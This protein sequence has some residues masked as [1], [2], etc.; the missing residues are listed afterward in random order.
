MEVMKYNFNVLIMK[1]IQLLILLTISHYCFGQMTFSDVTT[2]AGI[3]HQFKVYE[4]MFGGGACVFDVNKDG[5]EDLY[6]TGGMNSDAL[7]LNNGDGTF[8][9]IIRG[10]GLEITDDYVTQG[11]SG[12]DVNKD[13]WVDLFITTITTKDT[14]QTIP[15]AK[16]LFFLNNGDNTFKDATKK[17][18]LDQLNC[19][20]TAVSF[21][22]FNCDGF[23]DAYVGNYFLEYDGP[24]TEINDATIVN[25]SK[26]AQGYLLLNVGGKYFKNVYDDYGL[27]HKG[28]GFGGVWTDFDN[29]NDLDLLINHDFGYKAK[30]NYFLRNDY[31]EKK[32]SYIEKDID[33]DLRINAMTAAVGDYNNDE[34]LDYFIT[35]IKFNRF[36]TADALGGPYRDIA[37][38]MGT[39]IFT[40]SWGA[41]FADFDHDGD[42]DLYVVNGDLN[43]NCTPMTNFLFENRDSTFEDVSREAGVSDPGVG[44]GSVIFD[45][46]NDGDMDIFFINQE[47][48]KP[49]PVPTRSKLFRNDSAS[50]H[51]WLKVNIKGYESTTHG[52]GA[53]VQLMSKGDVIMIREVDG[54][55]SSHLS[56]NSTIVHFGIG[57]LEKI[58]SVV[59]I[60]PGGDRIVATGVDAN[61]EILISQEEQHNEEPPMWMWLFGAA[62]VVVVVYRFVKALRQSSIT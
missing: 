40:I 21:G 23:P 10:S 1:L 17:Y 2:Q 45:M 47:A 41:N 12:A 26:T 34:I 16:N 46:D 53:R 33:M 48:V 42:Q 38:E 6:V 22:D 43:P 7:Y 25:A 32:F 61:Q 51:N 36:M 14:S 9:D 62:C 31:P 44:R 3:D 19:F 52:L 35:N 8:S 20:S 57:E 60:Y 4:G 28:F 29:D 55:G 39:A 49:Y 27:S 50:D 15:R 24:L 56:Q 5:Y 18:K 11:V 58:D 59:V 37:E 30:P 54:G 13:G